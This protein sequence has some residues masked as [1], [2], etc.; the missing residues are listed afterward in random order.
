[1][2]RLAALA[3]VSASL[4]VAAG[5]GADTE[6]GGGPDATTEVRATVAKFGVA[7]RTHDWQTICDDLLSKALVTKIVDVGLP[8]ETAIEKGLGDVKNPTLQIT[9]VS[10][11]GARALV[12][13]HTT[14]AGQEASDDALQLVKED[15]EWRIASLAAPEGGELTEAPGTTAVPGSTST[16]KTATTKTATSK[17]TRTTSTTKKKSK[18][19]TTKKG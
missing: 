4:L 15:G 13:I 8:C 5:C 12:S 19:S 14:A 9:D 6:D 16:T 1:M 18:T 10:L 3:L 2:P 17:T 11:A 7:T